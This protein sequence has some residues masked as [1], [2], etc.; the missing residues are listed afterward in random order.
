MPRPSASA[1]PMKARANWLSD[2]DGLRSAPDRKLPKMLPTPIAAR[3]MPM[4]ARPAPRNLKA[5]GSI[6][7][8][9]RVMIGRGGISNSAQNLVTWVQRVVEV[10]AGQHR[11]DVGLQ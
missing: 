7:D 8:L 10:D 11:E 1:A 9:L 6:R 5:T 2:A 3:P 4:Q